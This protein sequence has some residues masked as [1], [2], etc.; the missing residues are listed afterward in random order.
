[1]ASS[2][3]DT[4]CSPSQ[5]QGQ[6]SVTAEQ[7]RQGQAADTATPTLHAGHLQGELVLAA[8]VCVCVLTRMQVSIKKPVFPSTY[9]A[10]SRL[11]LEDSK[12]PAVTSGYRQTRARSRST[13]NSSV[14][15]PSL[16]STSIKSTSM[17]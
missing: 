1:M 14:Q 10:A 9:S 12:L 4:A 15:L 13:W 16:A 5:G 6:A 17:R 2:C 8:C 7:G 3:A 11:W